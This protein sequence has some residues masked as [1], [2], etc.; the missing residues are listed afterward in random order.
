MSDTA[1]IGSPVRWIVLGGE[2]VLLQF[3]NNAD[4]N[5]AVELWARGAQVQDYH[6]GS[7]QLTLALLDG[8]PNGHP[9]GDRVVIHRQVFGS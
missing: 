5:L 9:P 4:R 7:S 6:P 8:E 1:Y 2:R 3:E